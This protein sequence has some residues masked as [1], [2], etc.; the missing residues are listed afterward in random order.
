MVLSTVKSIFDNSQDNSPFLPTLTVP[1]PSTYLQQKKTD[2]KAKIFTS[3]WLRIM[4]PCVKHSY[5]D[6]H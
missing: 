5:S 3:P 1:N 2:L 4:C 6:G